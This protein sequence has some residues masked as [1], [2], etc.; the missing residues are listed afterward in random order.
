MNDIAKKIASDKRQTEKDFYTIAQLRYER[1]NELKQLAS[2]LKRSKETDLEKCLLKA[3]EVIKDLIVIEK[4][5]A[6]PGITRINR[7]KSFLKKGE[8]IQLYN[9]C[10]K[11]LR[12]LISEAYRYN[13]SKLDNIE[14][15]NTDA[16]EPEERPNQHYFETL[17]VDDINPKEQEELK[18]KLAKLRDPKDQFVYNPV[19]VKNFEDAIITTLFN[20]NIQVVV[21]RYDILVKST[22]RLKLIRPFIS[23]LQHLDYANLEQEALAT[24][25]AWSIKKLRPEVDVYYVTNH[26]LLELSD[27]V[28]ST[29]R[30]IFYRQEDLQE[31]HL[32]IHR[33][34]YER[35]EAPFFK[36]L[37]EYASKPT[38]VFH[39]MPISR[40]N[41]IYKSFWIRD[42]GDF[43]GRNLFLAETSATTGGL[44]SL[45]QPTGPLKKAQEM[46]AKAFG[47]KHTYFVTNGTSTANKI[48]QQAVVKPGDYVLI[49]RDCHKS[50]HYSQVLSGGFPIYLDS[51]PIPEYSMYGAVP[52]SEIKEKLLLMKS[53]GKLDDV[54]MLVLTNCTFDGLV[55]NVEKVMQ[56]VLAIKPDMVFLWD[57]AWYGFAAFTHT[58]RKRSAMYVAR[59]LRYR[60]LSDS[61][62]KEYKAHVA[63]LKE[64]QIPQMPDP[65]KVVIRCYSTQSTHKT[66]SSLRQGSMIHVYDED[67]PKKKD[68]FLEAYM[69][70]TSTSANY[71]ILASMDVG[72][73]QVQFE[74]FEMVEKCIELSMIL[75]AKINDHPLLKKYFDVLTI[76]DFIPEKYRQ[77]KLSEYYDSK[78]GWNR[79][80]KAWGEDEFVLDPTKINLHIG[81]T[82]VDGDTFKNRFLMDKFNIQ[83]NKT[84]RNSVLFM[85]N[86]GTTR[87]SIAYLVS[88]LLQIAKELDEEKKSYTKTE[89]K[90]RANQVKSLC[91]DYPALPDFSAFHEVFRHQ[92]DVPG[93]DIRKAYY[94]AYDEENFDFIQLKKCIELVKSGKELVS[95]AFVIPYPPGFPVLVPGQVISIEILEFM[96]ALDVKEIHGYQP[97]LGLQVF[98]DKALR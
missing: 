55:Y 57:E 3:D 70:H 21:I 54:K 40:G 23:P 71:Q 22:N 69:T 50:H 28:V 27:S 7:I 80:E 93:G 60:Y 61:Y 94:L 56:E 72:R 98:R 81:R 16:E 85:T 6:Y 5:W 51:Y 49:D 24:Y 43:Y 47:S 46:A 4:Y 17:F 79:L 96:E 74:G 34:L 12:N 19:V 25:L 63:S 86:I 9:D 87:G 77:S 26:S 29:F 97:D 42:F 13:P 11:I 78:K 18:E 15:F 14:L 10:S 91:E 36:A 84:S 58:Y 35:F 64:G 62:K 52:L 48:V 95:C 82:G 33:G 75:R 53:K 67:F 92:P 41:S 73:R 38:S 1:W 68:A 89:A 39:A 32:S 59:K 44:D 37:T 31:L 8:F 66:L 45:L 20:Y 88:V 2:K 65:K 83:I 76:E 30:R 90:I